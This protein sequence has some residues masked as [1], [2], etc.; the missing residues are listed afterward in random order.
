MEIH[1]LGPNTCDILV[2][3]TVLFIIPDVMFTCQY[4]IDVFV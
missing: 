4:V 2:S 3:L 1:S